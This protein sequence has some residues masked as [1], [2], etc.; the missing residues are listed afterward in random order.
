MLK[1][2]SNLPVS[3]IR[4]AYFHFEALTDH[5]YEFMCVLC[6]FYPPLLVTDVDKKGI[7]E[8]SGILT[9]LFINLFHTQKFTF[10]DMLF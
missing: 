9:S 6:G 2:E 3:V 1:L 4:N 5:H 8:L 10:L 7:F